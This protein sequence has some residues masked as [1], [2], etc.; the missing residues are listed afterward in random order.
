MATESILT[1][2]AAR[3]KGEIGLFA[4]NPMAEDDLRLCANDEEVRVKWYSP[5]NIKALRYLWGLCYKIGNSTDRYLHW[6]EAMEDLKMRVGFTRIIFRHKK[7]ELRGKSLSQVSN[8]E[9]L[10]V[11]R[12]I[13]DEIIK[14]FV[15]YMKPHQLRAEVEE[16]LGARK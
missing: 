10:L 11:T 1:K 12:Q 8:E 13:E 14:E 9:L 6:R 15:P 3:W 2:R 4:D 16:M 7:F 5:R